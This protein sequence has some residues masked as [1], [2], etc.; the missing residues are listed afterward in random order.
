M[1]LNVLVALLPILLLTPKYILWLH[2]F[3]SWNRE[4]VLSNPADFALGIA[5]IWGLPLVLVAYTLLRYGR[6]FVVI[7]KEKVTIKKGLISVRQ[8]LLEEVAAV[9]KTA[10]ELVIVGH[11]NQ[12]L[13]VIDLR[14]M[15]KPSQIY[16]SRCLAEA[17]TVW[18]SSVNAD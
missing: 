10:Q 18:R 16:L 2:F 6:P 5:L 15:D 11:N 12:K 8:V 13:E 1:S 14:A 7:G 9:R 17:V 4:H 3:G